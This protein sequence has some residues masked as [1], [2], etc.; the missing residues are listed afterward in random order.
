MKPSVPIAKVPSAITQAGVS[1]WFWI[2]VAI[3]T[4]LRSVLPFNMTGRIILSI[5]FI[6][7]AR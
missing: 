6:F 5:E 4:R 1:F 3:A 7:A 2:S